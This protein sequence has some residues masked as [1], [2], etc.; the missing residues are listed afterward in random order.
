M[1]IGA[2]NFLSNSLP[3]AARFLI[4]T[5]QGSSDFTLG[6][7]PPMIKLVGVF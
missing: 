6:S 1:P 4:P 2:E 3:L 5:T 7:P